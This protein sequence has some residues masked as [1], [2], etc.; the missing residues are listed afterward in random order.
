MFTEYTY[1]ICT[2]YASA[3]ING[4]ESGLSDEEL[5]GLNDFLD[6]L[7]HGP[8]HWDVSDEEPDFSRDEVSGLMGDCVTF[9]YYEHSA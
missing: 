2:H 8:G 7:E 9:T 5:E 1:N 3:I 4:D 6:S